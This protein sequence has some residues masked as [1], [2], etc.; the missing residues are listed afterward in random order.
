[1]F[2]D[3]LTALQLNTIL[4]RQVDT[5][6]YDAQEQAIAAQ[7]EALRFACLNFQVG[8]HT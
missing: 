7:F 8:W 4:E 5:G 2:F 1:M 3:H 6:H